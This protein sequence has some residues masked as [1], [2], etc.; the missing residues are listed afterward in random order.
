MGG[1]PAARK[2]CAKCSMHTHI[3]S[4][5][6][7]RHAKRN[8][9]RVDRSDAQLDI[10]LRNAGTMQPSTVKVRSVRLRKS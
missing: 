9:R 2:Y 8:H 4:T 3:L 5:V 10:W 1:L 6:F 7:Q